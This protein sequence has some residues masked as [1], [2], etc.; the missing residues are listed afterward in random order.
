MFR[1]KTESRR[2]RQP[3]SSHEGTTLPS[4]S[5]TPPVSEASPS[6][7][8]DPVSYFECLIIPN[9]SLF[10]FSF[11]PKMFPRILTHVSTTGFCEAPGLVRA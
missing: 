3:G 4:C 11:F 7:D 10:F 2:E 5:V 8:L 9:I 1:T 6:K